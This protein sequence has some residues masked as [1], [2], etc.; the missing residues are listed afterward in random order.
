MYY[1]QNIFS[2]F[3]LGEKSEIWDKMVC[4]S[5]KHTDLYR[6]FTEGRMS[7]VNNSIVIRK[8]TTFINFVDECFEEKVDCRVSLKNGN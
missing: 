1:Y 7:Q 2:S 6:L 4:M 8:K 5:V 3:D